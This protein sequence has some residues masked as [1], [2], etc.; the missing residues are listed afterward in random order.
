MERLL[1]VV[2]PLSIQNCR[3]DSRG[4]PFDFI[5]IGTPKPTIPN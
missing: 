3:D 5:L 1:L 4:A 2:S